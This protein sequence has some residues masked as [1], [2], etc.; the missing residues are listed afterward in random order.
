MQSMS[1]CR[2]VE[3]GRAHSSG[4]Q[5]DSEE[6]A[7]AVG[8]SRVCPPEFL[9]KSEAVKPRA[10]KHGPAQPPKAVSQ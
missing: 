3:G 2:E 7:G 4:A 1:M 6:A 8:C 10:L 5:S 9:L